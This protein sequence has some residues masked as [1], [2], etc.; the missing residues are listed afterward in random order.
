LWSPPTSGA[1]KKLIEFP[2]KQI[3]LSFSITSGEPINPSAYQATTENYWWWCILSVRFN[4]GE[5]D[6][7]QSHCRFGKSSQKFGSKL[8][9]FRAKFLEITSA[10]DPIK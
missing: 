1:K 5:G 2:K 4:H 10:H 9:K 8:N 6:R 3:E 7:L